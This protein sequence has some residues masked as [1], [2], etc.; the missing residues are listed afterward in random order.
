MNEA[1]TFLFELITPERLLISRQ[2]SAVTM[3]GEYG[4]IGILPG[5]SKL[6]TSVKSGLVTVVDKGQKTDKLFVS[7]GFAEVLEDQCRLLAEEA[8][9]VA[10]L[11]VADLKEELEEL[12]EIRPTSPE[13]EEEIRLTKEKLKA[14]A[15]PSGR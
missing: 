2:V 6:V 9:P 11:N 15:E 3:P 1:K 8:I 10:E 14:A 12:E 5:H 4:Y 13:D 7:G